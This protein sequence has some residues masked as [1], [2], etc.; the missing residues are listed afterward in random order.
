MVSLGCYEPHSWPCSTNCFHQID[1][2]TL[3]ETL[4]PRGNDCVMY[5]DGIGCVMAL[6]IVSSSTKSMFRSCIKKRAC[7][8]CVCVDWA[9]RSHDRGATGSGSSMTGSPKF[10]VDLVST[11]AGR[12]EPDG[13]I[14]SP[15][16]LSILDHSEVINM[17]AVNV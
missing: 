12:D 1:C 10:G 2:L 4:Y 5:F 14:G 11:L 13:S 6:V 8:T 3:S 16:I 17:Q 9:A 7:Q 15:D